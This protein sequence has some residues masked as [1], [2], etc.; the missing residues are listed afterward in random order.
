MPNN[1]FVGLVSDLGEVLS[2]EE[3]D[4]LLSSALLGGA[5]DAECQKLAAWAA[6]TAIRYTLLQAVLSGQYVVSVRDDGE[7]AYKGKRRAST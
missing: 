1:P 4:T 5:T 7:P 2:A 3:L 6:H